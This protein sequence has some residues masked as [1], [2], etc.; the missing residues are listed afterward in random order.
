MTPKTKCY[1][2]TSVTAPSARERGNTTSLKILRNREGYN[3]SQS[4]AR[5]FKKIKIKIKEISGAERRKSDFN[6]QAV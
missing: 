2:N 1:V 3:K 6:P 5:K 4:E